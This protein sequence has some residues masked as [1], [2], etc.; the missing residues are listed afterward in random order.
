MTKITYF[1]GKN[2][3]TGEF[4][5]LKNILMCLKNQI[6]LNFLADEQ[7]KVATNIFL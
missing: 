1:F 7:N 3:F 6:V 5:A 4:Y 2:L